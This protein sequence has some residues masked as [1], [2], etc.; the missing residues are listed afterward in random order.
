[1]LENKYINIYIYKI[2]MKII[3]SV[4]FMP[5][6]KSFID[7]ASSVKVA[8]CWPRSLSAFLWTLTSSQSVKMQKENMANIQPS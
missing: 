6:N 1:M 3:F 4:L 7:Q 2:S 5:Y 8:G